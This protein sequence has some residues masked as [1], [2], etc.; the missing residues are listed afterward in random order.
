MMMVRLC[1][2]SMISL[3]SA[4]VLGR[5]ETLDLRM[6]ISTAQTV[7]ITDLNHTHHGNSTERFLNRLDRGIVIAFRLADVSIQKMC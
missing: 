4:T 5:G 7:G 1:S 2:M 6:T 3:I